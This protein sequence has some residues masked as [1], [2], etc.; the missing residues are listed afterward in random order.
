MGIFPKLTQ[1]FLFD[2]CPIISFSP[3][4]L[5]IN[6]PLIVQCQAPMI[7]SSAIYNRKV[8]TFF[9]SHELDL[10]LLLIKSGLR[11][12]VARTKL[13]FFARQMREK[14]WRKFEGSNNSC[15]LRV[16]KKARGRG[17]C[18]K[19]HKKAKHEGIES[20]N[21]QIK[22][23]RCFMS[24]ATSLGR[25]R[26]TIIIPNKVSEG[27]KKIRGSHLGTKVDIQWIITK[28]DMDCKCENRR[29]MGA[30]PIKTWSLMKQALRNIFGVGNYERQRKVTRIDEYHFNIAN[31]ASRV[32]GV[33]DKG[34]NMEKE[35]GNFLE[36]VQ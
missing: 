35:L 26:A 27:L 9:W 24:S 13:A 36:N 5:H 20:K 3:F 34:R 2:P 17:F 10:K 32:L 18:Y 15:E 33:E 16:W 14:W 11:I 12:A 28:W 21:I 6:L 30:Q 4:R 22:H 23:G 29:R 19:S 7:K 31:Y 1:F 25:I 8:D